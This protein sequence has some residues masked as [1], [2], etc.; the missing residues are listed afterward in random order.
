M[1]NIYV[2][3]ENSIGCELTRCRSPNEETIAATVQRMVGDSVLCPGDVIRIVE[4]ETED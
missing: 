2:V 3:L 1:T 4:L